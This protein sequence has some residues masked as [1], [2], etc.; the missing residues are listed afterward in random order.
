MARRASLARTF[1]VEADVLL[2]DEPFSGIDMAV[3]RRMMESLKN[4]WTASGTTVIMVTH[5]VDEALAVGD[6]VFVLSRHPVQLLLQKDISGDPAPL[7]S[8]I[9]A[10]L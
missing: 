7:R 1:A 9:L 3:K 10:L 2:L 4:L 5:D 6:E 8:E